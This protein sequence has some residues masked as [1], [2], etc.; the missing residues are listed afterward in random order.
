MNV[1]IKGILIAIITNPEW[2]F[3]GQH[4]QFYFYYYLVWEVSNVFFKSQFSTS[5]RSFKI[6]RQSRFIFCRTILEIFWKYMCPLTCFLYL[7]EWILQSWDI[8]GNKF[9]Y[10]SY[11]NCRQHFLLNLTELKCQ[12]DCLLQLQRPNICI[13]MEAK[14]VSLR[15]YVRHI[16]NG[17]KCKSM[18][19]QKLQEIW[20]FPIEKVLNIGAR[21]MRYFFIFQIVLIMKPELKKRST[22]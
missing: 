11:A 10:S 14:L 7:S 13:L 9:Q 12:R 5:L 8:L 18:N 21:S 1:H 15:E 17:I 2:I 3:S 19:K 16:T 20:K 22:K 6:I 4:Q